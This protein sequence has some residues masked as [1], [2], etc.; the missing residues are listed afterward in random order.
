LE[1]SE[2]VL[3]GMSLYTRDTSGALRARVAWASDMCA[4]QGPAA[5]GWLD[6]QEVAAP[7]VARLRLCEDTAEGARLLALAHTPLPRG[8]PPPRFVLGVPP[9]L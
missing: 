3:R 7:L 2:A 9:A 5:G 4:A 8:E 6:A 1:A